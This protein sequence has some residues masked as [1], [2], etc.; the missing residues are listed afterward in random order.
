MAA[1]LAAEAAA[2]SPA[3]CPAALPQGT[4]CWQGKDD[5]GSY[6][7]IAR[8]RD[9]NGVLVMHSH[10]GPRTAAPKPDSEVED[11]D[12]FAVIVKE[13]FAIAAPSYREGGYVGIAA[14]EDTENLRR[15]Y[16]ARF[17]AP[18][19]TIAHGQ[20]WGGG[21][22]AHLIE[23]YGKAPD[24]KPQYDGAMLTSGLVAG[25]AV[26]YDFRADLRAVYQY[27]CRNHPRPDEAQYPLWAGLP[28]GSTMTSRELERRIDECTGV[29]TP[30]EKRTAEQQRNLR[31]ILAVIRIP[32]GSRVGHVNWATF[33]FRDIVAKR[34]GG[35]NPFTNA[36]V[37]YA[38]SD[39][40]DALNKAVQ[41]FTA[42]PEAAAKFAAD[43]K[44]AGKVALPV[45]TMH[46]IDDPVVFVEQDSTYRAKL[47]AGGSADRLVQTWT[48]ESVHSYLQ[49]PEYAALLEALMRWIDAGEKPSAKSIAAA[50]ETHARRYEGGCRF[51]V[52]YRPRPLE[53][54]QYPR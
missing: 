18:R 50:C 12:R 25:N 17:G 5:N 34:L 39:D 52:G 43:G 15:I 42:D 36:G 47:E 2:Q 27:Y 33:L 38:G 23:R 19:R 14:A 49:S 51:D 26:G 48:R 6:Y 7:W 37:R 22:A 13:G 32:E 29:H 20:S 16:V 54:R 4:E 3:S 24:G 31:N 44:L 9:W 28:T 53:E 45:V 30:A 40:D 21:V 35:R 8:P 11:L 10:G 46:A 41:R 1:F